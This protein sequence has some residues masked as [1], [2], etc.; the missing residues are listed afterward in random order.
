MAYYL[1]KVEQPGSRSYR[2]AASAKHQIDARS[3][4]DAKWQADDII[5]INYQK[6]GKATMQL[7]DETGLVATRK[8]EGEWDV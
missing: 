5:D 3:L 8:G 4:N 6:I 2:E 1:L 7:F